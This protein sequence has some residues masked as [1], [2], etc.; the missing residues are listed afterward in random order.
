MLIGF[1]RSSQSIRFAESQN[2]R[3]RD[4]IGIVPFVHGQAAALRLLKAIKE[5]LCGF[6][7]AHRG[8][9]LKFTV[10]DLARLQGSLHQISEKMLFGSDHPIDTRLRCPLL[11]LVSSRK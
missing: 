6:L 10:V 8:F 5:S 7:D 11:I 4:A 9:T 1:S 2:G 3:S